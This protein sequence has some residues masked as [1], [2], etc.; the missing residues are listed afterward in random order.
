VHCGALV[1][2]RPPPRAVIPVGNLNLGQRFPR[3]VLLAQVH[4][5]N[6]FRIALPSARANFFLTGGG[7][8]PTQN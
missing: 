7:S 5:E 6:K 4:N 3:P 1:W 2:K 8:L